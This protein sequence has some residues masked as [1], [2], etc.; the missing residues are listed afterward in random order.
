MKIKSLELTNFHN[1]A[2]L[3]VDFSDSVTN[4]F[5]ANGIG[6]TTVL[7]ALHFLLYQ[8]DSKGR[9]DTSV[10][11]YKLDGQLEHNVETS[12]KGVFEVNGYEFTLQIVHK[13][14]WTKIS[15]TDDRKLTGNTNE[16]YI[17]GVPKKQNEYKAFVQE[18]FMDPWFSLTTN[19][20]AFPELPWKE[21]RKIL[22]D[23]IGD[24]KNDDVFAA[25]PE[26]QSLEADLERFTTEDLKKKL[27][28][29]IKGYKS[30]VDE[31]PA[32]IDELT[33]SLSDIT[34]PELQ[35]KQA[36]V[37]LLQAEKPLE[38]LH[39][40]RAAVVNGTI[41]NDLTNKIKVIESRME[42]IRSIR[43]ERIA[44]VQ[45]PFKTKAAEITQQCENAAQQLRLL[46]P[47]MAKIE[48]QLA[49]ADET[50][51][52]LIETWQSIDDEV[53]SDTECPCCHRPYTEDMLQPM[54]E[55]FNL[56]KADRLEKCN[57]DG[58]KIS[59]KIAA[60]K[61]EKT[62]LLAKVNKLSSFEVETAPRL[63][64]ENQQAMQAAVDRVPPVEE[65]IDPETHEKFYDLF[66]QKKL[67]NH[68]LEEASLDV[69]LQLQKIDAEIA[70][71]KKPV[72]EANNVLLRIKMDD[73]TRER[74][75]Q[76]KSQKKNALLKQGDCEQR[77]NLLNKFIVA[78]IDMLTESINNLF[79]NVSFKLFEKNIG[80]EGIKETCEI[81]MHGVPYRQLSFAEKHIAGME[82]IRVI[83]DKLH[84]DNPVFIDNRESIS[85]LPDA[86]GQLINLIVSAN[87]RRLRIEHV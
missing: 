86:P 54:R 28:N 46:R 21:Q 1:Q 52:T 31:V 56:D 19:P 74:I 13:E 12:V 2:A 7:D 62:E 78:K 43:R 69:K 36:E 83:A 55:K 6:K 82:I 53:F 60:L 48:Q 75:E 15:G 77:L 85:A 5:G 9:S 22:I 70:E 27:D 3:K 49:E 64:L 79:P 10:R 35:R 30:I 73:D 58:Q 11:P 51:K 14:K 84:M 45:E 29:E 80:N 33:K 41:V 87:D 39:A 57:M 81:T 37:T 59:E 40:K 18:Y 72:D 17:D 63:R 24:I 68:E 47:Q 8:K 32:R 23:L 42:V 71:A 4:I 66:E 38:E 44:Q 25:N 67:R 16:F 76:L 34:D 20:N 65:F 50:K 26:L 61:Q